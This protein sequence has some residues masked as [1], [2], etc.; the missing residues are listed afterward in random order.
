M[1]GRG[2][3]WSRQT[4]QCACRSPPCSGG[5]RGDTTVS[6]RHQRLSKRAGRRLW[7]EVDVRSLDGVE[8]QLSH[9]DTLHVDEMRLEKSFRGPKTFPTHIHLPPIRELPVKYKPKRLKGL[10]TCQTPGP[11]AKRGP[12]KHLI[13]TPRWCFNARY[14]YRISFSLKNKHIWP[15]F[16]Q[17]NLTFSVF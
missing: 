15:T 16:K 11:R 14:F 3:W 17:N 7:P 5:H 10:L 2:T 9:P 6:D 4:E 1:G 12:C 8:K 13:W